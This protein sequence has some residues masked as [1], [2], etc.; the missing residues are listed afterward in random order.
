M[1]WLLSSIDF[2]L[3]LSF[4]G[5]MYDPNLDCV[6]M[7]YHYVKPSVGYAFEQYFFGYNKLDFSGGWPAV[8]A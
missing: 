1:I 3:M 6:V 8:V 7:Y 5:V 4:V 2:Q